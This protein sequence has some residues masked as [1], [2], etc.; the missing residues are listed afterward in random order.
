MAETMPPPPHQILIVEDDDLMLQAYRMYLERQPD[1]DL[2]G[3]A[4]TADAARAL[5]DVPPLPDLVILDMRL[6]DGNSGMEL[7]AHIRQ[8]WPQLP[9]IIASGF[10]AEEVEQ[11][12]LQAG[13][14]AFVC[15]DEGILAA[16]DAAR[17]LLH[18]RPALL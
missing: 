10:L 11:E 5:L 7:L 16:L 12:V 17:A 13:A 4:D 8:R 15:K 6:G 1:L 2:A 14:A 9:V 18:G 3:L